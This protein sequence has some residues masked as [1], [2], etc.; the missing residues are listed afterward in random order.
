MEALIKVLQ[1]Y[2]TLS[3]SDQAKA[4]EALKTDQSS[5]RST[6]NLTFRYEDIQFVSLD[7]FYDF[8]ASSSTSPS[9][10]P[11]SHSPS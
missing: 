4:A 9:L 1:M 7:T 11:T 10:K 5:T 2:N 3:P 6:S 8:P